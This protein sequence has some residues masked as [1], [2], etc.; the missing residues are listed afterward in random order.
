M[1]SELNIVFDLAVI[2]ITAGFCTILSKALKQPLILGYIVAGFLV[3]PHL[4]LFPNL[5]SSSE[6]IE[7]WSQIGI[8]FLLFGLG[9]EFSFKKLL[10]VGSSALITAGTICVGMF[11]IGIVSGTAMGWSSLESVFLGGMLSMSSTTVIIKSYDDLGLKK[12]PYATLIFG[13]LVVED[14]IAVLLMVL[15]ST[16]AVSHRFS[17]G[18]MFMGLVKLVFFLVICFLVGIYVLPTVLKKVKR[19]LSDEI[20]LLVGIGLCFGMVALAIKFGFSSALGAFLMGSILAETVEGE[21]IARLTSGI[22]DLFGAIFFVSVGMMVDPA[23]IAD[24]WGTVLAIILIAMI[25]IL[26]FAT[27][28][29]LLS[30]QNLNTAVHTGFTMAQLGEFSFIIA[31][32]GCSLGVLSD[33][34]YPVIIASSVITT[35]TTPYMIKAADPALK[36]LTP[37]LPAKFLSA[38]DSMQDRK[39]DNAESAAREWKELIKLYLLR[40][41]LYGALVLAVYLFSKAFFLTAASRFL[42]HIG[43]FWQRMLCAVLTLAIL[44]PFLYGMSVGTGPKLKAAT[45]KLVSRRRSNMLPAIALIL[46]RMLFSV[47]VVLIVLNTYFEMKAWAILVVIALVFI[48]MLFARSSVHKYTR[49]EDRFFANLNEKELENQRNAPVATSVRKKMEGYDVHISTFEISPSSSFVGRKLRDLPFRSAHDVNVVKI[50][51]EGGKSVLVPGGDV[52]IFPYDKLVVVGTNLQLNRFE[53]SMQENVNE[54]VVEDAAFSV[55]SFVISD[56]SSFVGKT[57]RDMNMRKDNCM[58]ISVMRGDDVVT[59]PPA[60]FEFAAGD[61]I[62]IAGLENKL[63]YLQSQA[64]LAHR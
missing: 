22:K 13:T 49:L 11:I 7:Q 53:Q 39:K 34:V 48:L 60:D 42:P 55:E 1:G 10:K 5:I 59:N 45:R 38:L 41:S 17:G 35:F 36:W 16:L 40:V 57:L 64:G 32:L 27:S 51:R 33:F 23:I 43:D 62:W 47:I 44:A 19:H 63:L 25:G 28:G 56:E 30:G 37:R 31:G 26:L 21:R 3:G 61:I 12:R 4:G 20:L 2:L 52:S 15:L 18:D 46:L 54:A 58:V 14:L 9:L 24:H 8:I 50:L 29:A 6:S